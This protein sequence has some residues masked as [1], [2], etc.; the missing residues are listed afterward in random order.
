MVKINARRNSQIRA[1]FATLKAIKKSVPMRRR[2][3]WNWWAV[4]DGWGREASN[5]RMAKSRT[6]RLQ[7]SNHN[8]WKPFRW[9]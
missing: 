9:N 6:S 8:A 3:E 4:V 2:V 1:A 7:S 5:S